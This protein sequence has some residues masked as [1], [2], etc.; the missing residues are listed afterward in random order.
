MNF[1]LTVPGVFDG[2]YEENSALPGYFDPKSG[3]L[4]RSVFGCEMDS[5]NAEATV[6]IVPNSTV[7]PIQKIAKGSHG[8]INH[9]GPNWTP[10]RR[11][12]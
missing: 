8:E 9:R 11:T 12:Q 4:V 6:Q 7:V 3:K 1:I 10:T 2:R 5:M